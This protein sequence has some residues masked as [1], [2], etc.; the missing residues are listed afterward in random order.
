MKLLKFI[1]K[2]K[3]SIIA[4]SLIHII[5]VIFVASIFSKVYVENIP[6]GIVDMDN[7]YL[8]RTIIDQL[9]KSPGLNISY[10]LDSQVEL[11]QAIKD[12]KVSG[13]IIIPK[14]FNKDATKK[15]SPSMAL[16]IDETNVVV[17]N[18]IYA[19]CNSV[20]GTINA[21]FQLNVFEGK[22]M[23]PY[24]AEKAVTAFS[25][26]EHTLYEP[27]LSYMRYLMYTLVPYLL[28]GTF[29]ITF[30]VPALIKN[31]KEMNLIKIRSKDGVKNIL[32]ILARILMMITVAIISSF[33]G[34]C[35]LGKY[36]DLPLRGN[37]LEY[38]ALTF[39][40]LLDLTAMGI[41]FASLFNNLIYFIQG[42][43][44]I[45]LVTFLTSGVPFPE[46]A[47]PNGLPKIIKSIWPFMNVA[48]PF[49]LLNLK[50]IGWDIILPY[51]KNGV[52]YAL[53]W[54]PIGVGLYCGR[55]ALEKYKNRIQVN[56]ESEKNNL[57]G[58]LD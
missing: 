30:L 46:Y 38:I 51:I 22:N 11:Q 34:L 54:I 16:L 55:I 29:L 14:D 33:I 20:I 58:Q 27:Q 8:S 3:K 50:G 7:S 47:M 24:N 52:M 17:G 45:N 26:T 19:Y 10:Y 43:M 39:V 4:L 42:F 53:E 13:G 41:L 12:K 5:T 35:I 56:N 49:K 15:K 23:I 48:L 32:A 31:R 6:F 36:F 18:N 40:Y 1:A 28:Q 37:I 44:M 9:K 25:Y 2:D 57:I 21:G